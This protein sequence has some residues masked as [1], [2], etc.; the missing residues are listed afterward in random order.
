MLYYSFPFII[1]SLWA[2]LSMVAQT[3]SP[4]G[5]KWVKKFAWSF[6]ITGFIFIMKLASLASQTEV[7]PEGFILTMRPVDTIF[8]EIIAASVIFLGLSAKSVQ[9]RIQKKR[10]VAGALTLAFVLGIFLMTSGTFQTSNI[11]GSGVATLEGK[12][13]VYNYVIELEKAQQVAGVIYSDNEKAR[14]SYYFMHEEEYNKTNV[15][16]DFY[17]ADSLAENSYVT[18]DS[19]LKTVYKVGKYHLVI[20]NKYFL[21]QNVTYSLEVYKTQIWWSFGGFLLVVFS[22]S[23]LGCYVSAKD[24][25]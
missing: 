15:S 24:E 12:D 8:W 2:F 16:R 5:I 20:Q 1:A 14:F 22:T 4:M 21:G 9:K 3:Q 18:Q 6:Y 25:L 11:E 17:T 10:L 7:I 13:S 19:F 23:G